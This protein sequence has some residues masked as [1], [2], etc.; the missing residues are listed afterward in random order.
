MLYAQRRGMFDLPG[1]RRLH[2]V[3]TL[4][5]GGI[6]I[7]A[8]AL[9]SCLFV[10][11]LM[12]D[13]AIIYLGVA[14]L[15]VASAGYVD[16]HRGLGAVPRLT[17]Q[18]TAVCIFAIE[19]ISTLWRSLPGNAYSTCA[20]VMIAVLVAVVFVACVWSI[21]LHNFMD[22]S[23][24]I[25]A[26]QAVFVFCALGTL[27]A[28][29]ADYI[30]AALLLLWSAAV[31]G[32]LPFNFPRARVFMGDI[33]SGSIG[34]LIAA[35]IIWQMQR[36]PAA[37][38]IGLIACS[39]F[40]TDATCTLVSRI[41]RGRR[42]YTAHREHLY[43]WLARSGFSHPRVVALYAAW[44]LV[45]VAPLLYF[46]NRNMAQPG[47]YPVYHAQLIVVAATIALYAVAVSLWICGKRWSLR[48]VRSGA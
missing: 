38:C 36:E 19:P 6:G 28:C 23:D 31:V 16:D 12:G 22:G 9:V 24:G 8:A 44:N 41:W 7:V 14:L 11:S 40:V 30:H 27:A 47:R 34:L 35:G 21:N 42:W 5:G 29:H 25:L 13:L 26:T 39:A 33:G 1:Q 37:A 3:P 20:A 46:V 17:A 15:L 43:Q 10:Y 45:V 32:F 48:R 2:S 4:R 18:I